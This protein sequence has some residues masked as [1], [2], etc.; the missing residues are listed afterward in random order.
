M[1]E[2]QTK[3]LKVNIPKETADGIYSNFVIMN[4]NNSEFILDFGRIL[5]AVTEAKIYSR[6]VMAP[7]HC[8]RMMLL[9][10]KNIEK[11]E[12]KFG[13]ITISKKEEKKNIGFQQ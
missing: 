8:K 3:Q 9:V 12:E 10:Q 5:P 7:Q 2:R 1:K 13:E 11:F 6:I 4:F